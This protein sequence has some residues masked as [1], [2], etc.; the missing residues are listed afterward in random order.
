MLVSWFHSLVCQQDWDIKLYVELVVCS[1]LYWSE[2][3]LNL[4][5]SFDFAQLRDICKDKLTQSLTEEE[6][7]N[8]G[9]TDIL[10][11]ALDLPEYSGRVRSYGKGVSKKRLYPPTSNNTQAQFNNLFAITSALAKKVENY[12][13]IKA[14][15]DWLEKLQANEITGRQQPEKMAERQ[16][17]EK[18]AER[19]QSEDVLERPQQSAKDSYNPVDI[20]SIPKG[21]SPINIYLGFSSRRL[22]A[23]GKLHNTEGDTV[24][25]I[26]LPP[27]YVKVAID[28]S[29]ISD[30]PLPISIEYGEVSTVGQAIGTIVPWP[31]KLVELNVECQKIP[32]KIHNKDKVQSSE[33]VASP[34]KNRK[35]LKKQVVHPKNVGS[36]GLQKLKFLDDYTK[37]AWK[38]GTVMEIDMRGDI[39]SVG[40]TEL[41]HLENIK[42]IV[43]HDWLSASV[44]TL[45]ARYLYDK[46]IGPR[47]LT[48]KISFLSP[49][50]SYSDIEGNDIASRLIETK[51]L[52]DEK[53]ILAPYNIGIHWVLFVINPNA[54]DIYFLDPLGGE[55]SDHGSIKTK[56]ENA[57]QIY[58]AW[59][60]NKISKSKKDKIKWH[61]IKCP[62]QINTIDC[63]YFIMRFMKEVIMEYPNKIPDNYFHRHRHST[64]SK[65][66]LD[67]VKEE[68]ATYMVEDVINDAKRR[69]K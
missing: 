52:K 20:D 23:R 55:P 9:P 11:K 8:L 40:F 12:N 64:Y 2:F 22:V 34:T 50:V 28:V 44:I 49:H 41:L 45:Y 56:F 4:A 30:A 16:Q 54:E 63:G 5:H 68:W 18:M 6:K 25:G 57:I 10:F 24:H 14:K 43:D 33:S 58:R 66:K 69:P 46:L 62:R 15:L 53:I 31:F 67:E 37:F 13:E 19:Q 65:G 38:S 42:E 51:V 1:A 32:K 3:G 36:A 61:K 27:G 29:I 26:K 17:P 21:I 60:E 7:Q 48:H 47:G 39:F 59:C 35:I